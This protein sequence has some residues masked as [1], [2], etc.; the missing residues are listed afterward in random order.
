MTLEKIPPGASVFIDANIFIYHFVGQSDDCSRFIQRIEERE[1]KGIVGTHIVAEIIH[2]MMM[3]EALQSGLI[4]S[5][6]PSQK[7][8]KQRKLIGNLN[9]FASQGRQLLALPLEIPP[10]TTSLLQ[11]GITTATKHHLLMN[12]ALIIALMREK[13][14]TYLASADRDF[15]EIPGIKLYRP[16]DI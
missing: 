9:I 2:R 5:G 15:E 11:E 14:I 12:D 13:N 8:R 16:K 10:L 4:T 1:I 3:L 7:V 6:S